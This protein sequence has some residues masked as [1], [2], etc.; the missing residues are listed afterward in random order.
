MGRKKLKL[1]HRRVRKEEVID[2]SQFFIPYEN[3]VPD[4]YH[5]FY[6][7]ETGKI[8]GINPFI[9]EP[10][11]GAAIICHRSQVKDILEEK[12]ELQSFIVAVVDKKE[13]S[14]LGLVKKDQWLRTLK[15]AFEI[16]DIPVLEEQDWSMEFLIWL[17]EDKQ[18]LEIMINLP[19]LGGLFSAD[20]NSIRGIANVDK[21]VF[22]LVDKYDPQIVYQTITLDS[23]DLV[24]NQFILT[25]ISEWWSWELK[26]RLSIKTQKNF[27]RYGF[28]FESK[29][30][31]H[32]QTLVHNKTQFSG[33]HGSYKGHI[34][35]KKDEFGYVE[36]HSNILD[37][38]NYRLYKDLN[39]HIVDR[40]RPD[41]YHGTI[42]VPLDSIRNYGK[43]KLNT[44]FESDGLKEF[45][46][47]YENSYI[48]MTVED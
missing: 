3:L 4:Q 2:P 8:L 13:G 5:V 17:Y 37:P 11:E 32:T 43:L 41:S 28:V 34:V 36:I 27:N 20:Q 47:M 9:D 25:D 1:K 38:K 7:Q 30:I 6:D 21:I 48:T 31:D 23:A 44:R 15:S 18:K 16:I 26:D 35:I 42:T 39:I 33:E 12:E 40:N 10:I 24:S 45:D 29:F 46:F 14:N 22:Y 19:V